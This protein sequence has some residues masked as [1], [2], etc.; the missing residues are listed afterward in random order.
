MV[1]ADDEARAIRL[2]NWFAVPVLKMEGKGVLKVEEK[3]KPFALAA[4]SE[5]IEQMS[6]AVSAL[7]T[8]FGSEI[9]QQCFHP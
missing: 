7:K 5:R 9:R 1:K 8:C 2:W 3:P 6:R 4:E